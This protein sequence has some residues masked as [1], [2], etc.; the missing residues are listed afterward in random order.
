MMID[1]PRTNAFEHNMGSVVDP[2]YV[3]DVEVAQGLERELAEA[4]AE[5]VRL[6]ELLEHAMDTDTPENNEQINLSPAELRAAG[7]SHCPL[8]YTFGNSHRK[9][10]KYVN[11]GMDNHIQSK[12]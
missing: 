8:C 2:H 6:R 1:T 9:G 10:C 12:G 3:V 5:I 7:Q 4:H 11:D